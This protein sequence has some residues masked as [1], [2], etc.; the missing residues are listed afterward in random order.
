MK[1][2]DLWRTLKEVDLE[3]IRSEAEARFRVVVYADEADDARRVAAS[4]SS[5]SDGSIHPW[6]E[7]WGAAQT[8]ATGRK[9]DVIILVTREAELPP[10]LALLRDDLQAAV[11]VL[12][13]VLGTTAG[14]DAVV[15]SG[16]TAR[17]AVRRLDEAASAAISRALLS[18]AVAERRLALARQL[19]AVRDGYIDEL[20]EQTSRANA[21]YAFTAAVAETMPG[22]NVP[23]NLADIVILTKNQLVMAYRICLAAGKSG[24]P[25]DVIG[26]VVGVLGSGFL[27]RQGARSLIG[28]VPVL[29]IVP[30][31][32][33]AYA[34]TWAVGR[35]V[36]AWAQHGQRITA[37]ALKRW[38]SDA[39]ASGKRV[40]TALM[41]RSGR[42]VLPWKRRLKEGDR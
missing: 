39:A 18:V 13:V 41:D 4:L 10:A 12:T 19:P 27:M 40:A 22:L 28:L 2:P 11:P 1:L 6:I 34:G 15:R 14:V 30:K 24:A 26:E 38:Q 20:V 33:I 36:S 9:P 25:Q 16:E 5:M 7:A 3:A 8:P 42:R 37:S 21:T 23:L 17:V 31:V 35:A 29:G 32:A